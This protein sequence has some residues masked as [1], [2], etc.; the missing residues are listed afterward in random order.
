MKNFLT[1]ALYWVSLQTSD[2][3]TVYTTGSIG[4]GQSS[5]RCW[6]K[7]HTLTS[8][9][10]INKAYKTISLHPST[11]V[12]CKN[13]KSILKT[14]WRFWW[15]RR[16]SSFRHTS[17]WRSSRLCRLST[18]CS[19]AKSDYWMVATFPFLLPGK[20]GDS[21]FTKFTMQKCVLVIGYGWQLQLKG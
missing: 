9:H 7:A 10:Q 18:G 4:K 20:I 15:K 13:P 17:P 11:S 12:F 14:K 1:F 19:S 2:F 6:S 21:Q 3:M 16:S 8:K 5:Q